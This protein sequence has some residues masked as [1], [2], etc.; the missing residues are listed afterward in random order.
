MKREFLQRS[1]YQLLLTSTVTFANPIH[2]RTNLNATFEDIVA[3]VKI[4]WTPC[5]GIFQCTKLTVPFDY[6]DHSAG[7]ADIAFLKLTADNETV[8]TPSIHLNAGGP[9]GSTVGMLKAL[10]GI[11]RQK[12]GA[13]Y[14][15][16]GMDPRGVNNSGPSLSCF[17][18]PELQA[19]WLSS[20]GDR[21]ADSSSEY[22]LRK[23]YENARAYAEKCN[24]IHENGPGRY[25]T[26]HAVASDLLHFAKLEARMTFATLYP[27]HVGR[28]IVDSVLDTD[29]YYNGT[30]KDNIVDANLA[31]EDFFK[32]CYEA[33]PEHCELYEDVVDK[34]RERVK[35]IIEDVKRNHVPV[36][37]PIPKL[38]THETITIWLMYCLYSQLNFPL[39]ATSLSKLE[40]GDGYQVSFAQLFMDSV[41][42]LLADVHIGCLDA[43]GRGSLNDFEDFTAHARATHGLSHWTG[44][45]W[46][47]LVNSNCVGRSIMPVPSQ[48]INATGSANT[49]TPLLFVTQTIDAATPLQQ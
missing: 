9:G 39:L 43:V 8:D 3:S 16:I 49:S 32:Q 38:V 35:R 6:T 24:T 47:G 25:A 12:F 41:A 14:N 36:S 28:M 22:A 30:W 42:D 33:G 40:D 23:H 7:T 34:I 19:R 45:A 27:D 1:I 18:S 4:S 29:I 37:E 26:I 5:L 15:Y 10:G 20:R 44:D 2:P 48:M 17:E 21:I 13:Q 46:F 11:V 31:M